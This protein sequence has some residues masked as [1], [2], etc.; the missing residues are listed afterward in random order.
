MLTETERTDRR[1]KLKKQ[2]LVE[3]AG[4]AC[5]RCGYDRCHRALTFHHRD[6]MTKEFDLSGR[7]RSYSLDRLRKEAAK[8]DLVCMNCHMELEG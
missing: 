3:E 5:V 6:P 4:G 8:C 1:R 2:I 7:A